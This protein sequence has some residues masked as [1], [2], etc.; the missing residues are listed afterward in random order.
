MRTTSPVDS[1]TAHPRVLTSSRTPFA[2]RVTGLDVAMLSF[3][4]ALAVCEA[5]LGWLHAGWPS[6][7]ALD[8]AELVTM[9]GFCLVP[10]W[11]PI[12][13]R[14]L[15]VGATAGMLELFTDVSGERVVHSLIYP[16]AEP[17]IWA[18][19]AYMP[20]AWT[21]V[22]AELAYFSWRLPALFPSL[23]RA[24]V[25]A[26][27]ALFGAVTVPFYEEMAYHAGWWRY[28][29]A[30]HIGHTPLY[31]VLFEGMIASALPIVTVGI[32]RH[33]F[34]RAMLMGGVIGVWMP[35]AALCAWLVIGR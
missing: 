16:S 25:V 8:T 7:I 14:L 19:P 24:A 35:V 17:T 32:T 22:I 21:C 2:R 23:S 3:Y 26:L 30:P 9:L 4:L 13:S 10:A 12:M 11:L 27:S 15:V 28:A 20:V 6:A 33:G 18:S 1:K 31:V 29:S 5:V 34:K